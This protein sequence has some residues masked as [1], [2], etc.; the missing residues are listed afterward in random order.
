MNLT[1]NSFLNVNLNLLTCAKKTP[2]SRVF[3][4]LYK[5]AD[6]YCKLLVKARKP[7][8]YQGYALRL[9]PD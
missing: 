2:A 7:L 5:M 6:V 1:D 8:K 3:E 9:L 4:W